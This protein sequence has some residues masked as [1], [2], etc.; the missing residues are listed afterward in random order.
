[1]PLIMS[2]RKSGIFLFF[3]SFFILFWPARARADDAPPAAST[4]TV[5]PWKDSAEGSV[6]STNGNSRGT[7]TSLKDTFDYRW[8]HNALELMGSGLGSSSGNQ[9]TAEQYDASEKVTRNFTEDNYVYETG[10]WNKNRFAGIQNRYQGSV[11]LGRM[12]FEF[13]NDK[14]QTEIGPGYVAEERTDETH[15]D[16]ESGRAFAKYVHKFSPSAN[17]TQSAE[18]IEDF[19]QRKDYR[20][21]TESALLTTISTHFSIKT[22]FVWHRIAEPVPGAVKDDTIT[23]VSLVA[24]Y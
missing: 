2:M 13:A 24:N 8:G 5:K 19:T 11:G 9:V 18:Y 16:F 17:F 20:L 3:G 22:S 23:S 15:N 1:M 14:L 12:L 6:V 4:T 7:T 10:E 21:N